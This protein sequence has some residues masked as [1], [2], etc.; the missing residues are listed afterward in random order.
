MNDPIIRELLKQFNYFCLRCNEEEHAIE[1]LKYK[2]KSCTSANEL[3][4]I[5]DQIASHQQV[6]NACFH[7]MCRAGEEITRLEEEAAELKE[8]LEGDPR[9]VDEQYTEEDLRKIMDFEEEVRS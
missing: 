5:I 4:H 1:V 2:A 9:E 8:I 7:E 6:S 3:E